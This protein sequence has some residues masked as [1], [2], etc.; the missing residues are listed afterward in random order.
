MICR[1]M[2]RRLGRS[3]GGIRRRWRSR[4]G[5]PRCCP[6]CPMKQ[7]K[8]VF[9]RKTPLI[10]FFLSRVPP[11]AVFPPGVGIS[12]GSCEWLSSLPWA[13]WQRWRCRGRWRGWTRTGCTPRWWSTSGSRQGAPENKKNCF[14]FINRQKNQVSAYLSHWIFIVWT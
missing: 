3:S 8:C 10:P 5:C 9:V 2:R 1:T 14:L 4:W 7:F 12:T 11:A 6:C 13:P